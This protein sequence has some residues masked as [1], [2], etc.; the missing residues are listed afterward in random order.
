MGT[1][2]EEKVACSARLLLQTIYSSHG[3]TSLSSP[4]RGGQ[5]HRTDIS[6]HSFRPS[7]HVYPEVP[8]AND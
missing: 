1:K 7:A 5:S 6:C 4:S 8:L 2:K 3:V